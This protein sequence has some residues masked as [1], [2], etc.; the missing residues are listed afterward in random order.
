LPVLPVLLDPR[1]SFESLQT[2]PR[3]FSQFLTRR[4]FSRNRNFQNTLACK[5]QLLDRKR[6]KEQTL[7]KLRNRVDIIWRAKDDIVETIRFSQDELTEISNRHSELQQMIHDEGL[8]QQRAANATT[9]KRHENGGM[10]HQV[11]ATTKQVNEMKKKLS[12]MKQAKAA[13]AKSHEENMIRMQEQLATAQKSITDKSDKLHAV[14]ATLPADTGALEEAWNR[15]IATQLAHGHPASAPMAEQPDVLPVLDMKLIQAALEAETKATQEEIKAKN[16]LEGE[17]KNLRH[18]LETLE[19]EHC[20]LEKTQ[21]ELKTKVDQAVKM[22]EFREE[23]ATK[24]LQDLETIKKEVEI[25]HESVTGTRLHVEQ[26]QAEVQKESVQLQQESETLAEQLEEV[27]TKIASTENAIEHAANALQKESMDQATEIEDAEQTLTELQYRCAKLW[28]QPEEEDDEADEEEPL[29][30]DG[31]SLDEVNAQIAQILQGKIG[32]V[33]L[34]LTACSF[35]F[36]SLSN[37]DPP[38]FSFRYRFS[39]ARFC[40]RRL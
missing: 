5:R 34:V 35:R 15:H 30:D 2:W 3:E 8:H 14:K 32:V 6:Q 17:V 27:K 19:S 20:E 36:T 37:I 31:L 25:L 26:E 13:A 24:F 40:R 11:D 39:N 21:P 4:L 9:E 7:E 28:D 22:E 33:F 10:E 38:F 12:D 29:F 1:I 23:E 16:I 18:Q